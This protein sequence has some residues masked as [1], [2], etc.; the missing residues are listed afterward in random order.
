MQIG[1][2]PAN[3]AAPRCSRR[4]RGAGEHRNDGRS[5]PSA[6]PQIFASCLPALRHWTRRRFSQCNAH[7]ADDLVQTALLRALDRG[8]AVSFHGAAGALAYLRKIVLNEVRRQAQL[9]LRRG[10]AVQIE[11]SLNDGLD[12]VF[13]AMQAT[14]RARAYAGALRTLSPRQQRHLAWRLQHGLSFIQIARESGSS[15]DGARMLVG[16]ALRKMATAL[17]DTACVPRESPG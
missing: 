15:I 9:H 14:E 13:H 10:I 1:I 12:P 7:D 11:D 6:H 8:D 17:R 5:E 4:V 2:D 16:R 3:N